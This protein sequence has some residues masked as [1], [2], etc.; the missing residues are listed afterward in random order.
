VTGSQVARTHAGVV[1]QPE[2]HLEEEKALALVLE[3]EGTPGV[4]GG[5]GGHGQT[6]AASLAGGS[7]RELQV[8]ASLPV[9]LATIMMQKARGHRDWPRE[10]QGT[11]STC[12]VRRGVHPG[13]DTHHALR[14]Q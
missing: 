12:S 7:K 1:H 14:C 2:E 6:N 9:A 10:L 13:V 8:E 3:A 11:T 5:G 4:P